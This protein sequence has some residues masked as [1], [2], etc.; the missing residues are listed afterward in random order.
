MTASGREADVRKRGGLAGS[1]GRTVLNAVTVWRQCSATAPRRHVGV[2]CVLD[3]A[4]CRATSG[5][6]GAISKLLAENGV[7]VRGARK[8]EGGCNLLDAAALMNPLI[9]R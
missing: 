7:E 8:A 9:F 6:A 2:Q 4:A 5:F 3:V 1:G